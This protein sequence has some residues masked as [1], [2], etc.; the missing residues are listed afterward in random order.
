MSATPPSIHDAPPAWQMTRRE[1]QEH[2]KSQGHTD[3]TENNRTYWQEIESAIHS[4]KPIDPQ[5]LA[6]YK[7][8]KGIQ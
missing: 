7:Q 6:E 1:Y 4:G 2:R 8:L 3:V 5:I